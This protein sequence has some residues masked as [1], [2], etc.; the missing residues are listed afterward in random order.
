MPVTFRAAGSARGAEPDAPGY[1]WLTLSN[2]TPGALLATIGA[3]ITLIALPDVFRGIGIDPGH[4]SPGGVVGIVN[5]VRP[6]G[7]S[8]GY[9]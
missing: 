6:Q 9:R 4:G 1:K 3:S 7:T 2:T 8:H 5:V